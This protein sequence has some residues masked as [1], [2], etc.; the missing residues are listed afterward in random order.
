MWGWLRARKRGDLPNEELGSALGGNGGRGDG[1]AGAGVR[2]E[3]VG[4]RYRY[5]VLLSSTT[6]ILQRVTIYD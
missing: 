5:T 1:G 4:M 2:I 3:G 6:P